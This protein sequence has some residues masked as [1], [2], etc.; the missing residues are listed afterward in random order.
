MVPHGPRTV[1]GEP[2]VRVEAGVGARHDPL[3]GVTMNAV[4]TL[5]VATGIFAVNG[6]RDPPAVVDTSWSGGRRRGR[7]CSAATAWSRWTACR[8]GRGP[9]SR[10]GRRGHRAG[11]EVRRRARRAAPER[12]AGGPEITQGDDNAAR[13]GRR[14]G[15]IGMARSRPTTSETA[16][17]RS[18]D[19]VGEAV[20]RG[21]YATWEMGGSVL[22]VPR[23]AF[24]GT[25]S[26]KTWAARSRSPGTS[27][28]AAKD[29]A[30]SR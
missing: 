13:T 29:G 27:V 19:S 4:L 11:G 14:G 5:V 24:Q 17:V 18:A 21:W 9:R 23:R 30:R 15:K 16:P 26:V 8:C 22:G 3:A 12:S 6:R 1:P 2:L 25:V 28:A 20:V 7:D 10:R